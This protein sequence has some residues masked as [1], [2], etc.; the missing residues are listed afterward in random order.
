MLHERHF[1]HPL[2]AACGETMT[3]TYAKPWRNSRYLVEKYVRRHP[4]KTLIF[5]KTK[6]EYIIVGDVFLVKVN[7]VIDLLARKFKPAFIHAT[8]AMLLM[9]K[10]ARL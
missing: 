10:A 2:Q 5:R 8:A 4:K 6:V 1:C 9:N 7:E 3:S